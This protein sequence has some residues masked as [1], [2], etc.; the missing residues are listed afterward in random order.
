MK[1]GG[2]AGIFIDE[3][4]SKFP[5]ERGAARWESIDPAAGELGTGLE[6]WWQGSRAYSACDS[7]RWAVNVASGGRGQIFKRAGLKC[8]VWTCA[9][10]D[11]LGG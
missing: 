1:V 11:I 4:L 3:A 8:W 5:G 7:L 9:F 6:G 10:V 2:S